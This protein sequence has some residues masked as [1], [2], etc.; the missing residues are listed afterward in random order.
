MTDLILK[1]IGFKQICLQQVRGLVESFVSSH[2]D[3]LVRSQESVAATFG[4]GISTACVIDIGAKTSSV[5]CIEEGLVLP[6]TR[7]VLSRPASLRFARA[8]RRSLLYSML[9]DF[10]GDDVTQFLHTLLMRTGLPYRDA[11]LT[12]WYDFIV[13]EDLKERMVVLSEV[14][15]TV[16]LPPLRARS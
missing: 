7:C 4:A 6:E 10:G 11:D 12:R 14:C 13:I 8:E 16:F 3:T 15:W 5:T 1:S 2:A 9:L